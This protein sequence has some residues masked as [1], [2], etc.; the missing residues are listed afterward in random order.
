MKGAVGGWSCSET[1]KSWRYSDEGRGAARS[2]LPEAKPEAAAGLLYR[3]DGPFIRPVA[4][5]T[6]NPRPLVLPLTL[7]SP[8]ELDRSITAFIISVLLQSPLIM[9]RSSLITKR[10]AGQ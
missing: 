5:R 3:E 10:T 6:R 2:Q 4:T 8:R 1:R 7:C 9:R